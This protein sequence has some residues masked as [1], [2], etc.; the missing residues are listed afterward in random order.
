MLVTAWIATAG[1]T[2][3]SGT[4]WHAALD[5]WLL[6]AAPTPLLGRLFIVAAFVVSLI[7]AWPERLPLDVG[8]TGALIAFFIALRARQGNRAISRLVRHDQALDGL[9]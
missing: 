6:R 8:M 1:H 3:L 9:P 7:K 5:H 4:A 2:A